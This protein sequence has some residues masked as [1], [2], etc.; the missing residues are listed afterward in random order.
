MSDLETYNELKASLKN[1]DEQIAKIEQDKA[2]NKEIIKGIMEKYQVKNMKQLQELLQKMDG[3][4]K[5][6]VLEANNYI[7]ESQDKIAELDKVL[8]KDD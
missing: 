1:V 3:E 2:V 5:A 4:V 8:L 6:L 7:S